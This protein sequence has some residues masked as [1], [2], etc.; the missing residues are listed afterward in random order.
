MGRSWRSRVA[1]ERGSFT[2][3]LAA[4]LPAL[5]LLLVA[6]LTA[7]NA[8]G[9]RVACVDAAREAALAAAR[10]EPGTIAGTRYAPD[11]AEV[12]VTVAGDRVT[13]TVRAPVR[14]LGARL[15]RLVVSREAVAALE[16][17]APGAVP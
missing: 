5:M 11:G 15:P 9:T 6:G 12:T 1:C 14:T 7:V 2:A 16:P 10:G 4:G 13:A 3:E 8:V 17:G